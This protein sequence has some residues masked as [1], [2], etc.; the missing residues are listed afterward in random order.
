[1]FNLLNNE[2]VYT[3]VMENT[4]FTLDVSNWQ[5]GFYSMVVVN[6]D[7]E[8]IYKSSTKIKN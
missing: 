5:S 3:G 1:M 6:N 8:L 7:E 2:Q 4:T